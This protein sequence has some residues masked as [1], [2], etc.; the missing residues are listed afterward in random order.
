MRNI[1]SWWYWNV[2]SKFDTADLI[3]L[4]WFPFMCIVCIWGIVDSYNETEKFSI[5]CEQKSG[6]VMKGLDQL[7]CVDKSLVK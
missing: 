7:I 3:A 2:S 6:I 1:K 5:Q 4:I